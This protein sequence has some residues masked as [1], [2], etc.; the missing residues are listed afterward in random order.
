MIRVQVKCTC[1]PGNFVK[2]G[3]DL[4]ISPPLA[5]ILLQ[6]GPKDWP[7]DPLFTRMVDGYQDIHRAAVSIPQRDVVVVAIVPARA[8]GCV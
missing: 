6:E 3:S 7:R 5:L 1:E 4:V 8:R 2:T